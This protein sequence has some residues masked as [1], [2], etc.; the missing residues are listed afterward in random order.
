M[1]ILVTGANGQLGSEIRKREHSFPQWNF[2][3]FDL[4][5]L[6][7]LNPIKLEQ[8]IFENKISC[9]INCAAYTAVDLAEKEVDKAF[10]I[11]AYALK[12]LAYCINHYHL[13]FIHISTDFVFD[14]LSNE[15]YLETDVA[16][17]LNQFGK[18]KLEGEYI[19]QDLC[20]NALILRV[21]RLY[22]SDPRNSVHTIWVLSRA[23]AYL[24]IFCDQISCPTWAGDLAST[25][26]TILKD[27]QTGITKKGIYHFANEGIASCY[28]FVK[29]IIGYPGLKCEIS[30]VLSTDFPTPAKRPKFSALNTEKIRQD[31]GIFI[32]HW[33]ESLK[34]CIN[35]MT[36]Y[37]KHYYS[38]FS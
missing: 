29:E 1:N 23:K 25:I 10:Q 31:Y 5:E 8:I 26:L 27:P 16:V 38:N 21:S 37:E 30:P 24:R 14:G 18:S 33:K 17:P 11:N 13:K 34:E 36:Q 28:D 9:V 22:S 20:P 32:P 15:P 6:N 2:Y 3:F 4:P 35:E 12:D 19:V 7:L